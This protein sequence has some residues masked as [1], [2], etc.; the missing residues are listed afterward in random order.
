MRIGVLV[1]CLLVVVLGCQQEGRLSGLVPAVGVVK[2]KGEPVSNATVMFAPK[3]EGNRSASAT[4]DASGRFSMMTLNPGDGVY[5]GEYVVLIEKQEFTGEVFTEESP[6]GG[7][8]KTT[9]TR[10]VVQ[11]LPVKF[12]R[13]E[14]T[15][16]TI[17]I[18]AKGDRKIEFNL[19][20]NVD[21]TPKPMESL[22]PPR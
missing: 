18:P 16:L 19:D 1:C 22:G 8:G 3:V 20:G 15:D 6:T 17:S 14:T 9:D 12:S 5:P 7:L 2:F 4:T 13:Q 11:C 10:K 21:L